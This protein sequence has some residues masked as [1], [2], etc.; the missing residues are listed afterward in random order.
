MA[1][2]KTPAIQWSAHTLVIDEAQKGRGR[3]SCA[4][5]CGK[6]VKTPTSECPGLPVYWWESAPKDL[7][8]KTQLTEKRLK[9]GE[10]VRGLIPY[11][12]SADGYIRLYAE[13]EAMPMKARTDAQ[14]AGAEKAK[15]T[16]DKNLTCAKCGHISSSKKYMTGDLCDDCDNEEHMKDKQ[17]RDT[18][19]ARADAETWI[20]RE[21]VVFDFETTGLYKPR[22]VSLCIIDHAGA[23]LLETLINPDIPIPSDATAIHGVTDAMVAAAPTFAEIYEKFSRFSMANCG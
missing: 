12:K 14:K 1:K 4:V 9:P 5:C 18:A 17:E 21:F 7:F 8:T 10:H 6:W 15:A 19:Y 11:D 16:R 2:S 22:P 23:V 13:S 20:A 3:F